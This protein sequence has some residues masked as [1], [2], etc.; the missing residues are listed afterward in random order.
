MVVALVC[1]REGRG[2]FL[3]VERTPTNGVPQKCDRLEQAHTDVGRRQSMLRSVHLP[4]HGE[5]V[6]GICHPLQLLKKL[7]GHGQFTNLFLQALG[8]LIPILVVSLLE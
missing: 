1:A 3:C 7:D 5:R 4:P 6:S 2:L 8:V